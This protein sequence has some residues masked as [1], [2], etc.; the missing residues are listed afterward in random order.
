MKVKQK[1]LN[2]KD[3]GKIILKNCGDFTMVDLGKKVMILP[4]VI[5]KAESYI[6][7]LGIV[8]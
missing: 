2:K 7:T 3:G 6:R 8:K 4:M 5:D 1:I